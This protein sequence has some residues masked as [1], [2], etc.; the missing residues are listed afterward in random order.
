MMR[1]IC[2][3][4][5][6]SEVLIWG[7]K[8]LIYHNAAKFRKFVQLFMEVEVVVKLGRIHILITISDTE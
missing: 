4:S 2:C 6:A 5:Y 7:T 3:Q 1:K 8:L